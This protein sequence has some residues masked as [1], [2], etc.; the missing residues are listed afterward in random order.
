MT[1][2]SNIRTG[3]RFQDIT[4][5]KVY[6]CLRKE[7]SMVEVFDGKRPYAWPVHAKVEPL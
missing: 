3:Q 6:T 2:L 7:G 5:K 1:K 4:S